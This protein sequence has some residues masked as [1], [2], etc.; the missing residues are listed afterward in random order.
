MT[1]VWGER[2]RHL[3]A[4]EPMAADVALRACTAFFF[5]HAGSTGGPVLPLGSRV[6]ARSVPALQAVRSARVPSLTRLSPTP[7]R[8]QD[9]MPGR[10]CQSE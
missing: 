8:H 6:F 10:G 9:M 5:P 2:E 4:L 7:A 3:R 1:T